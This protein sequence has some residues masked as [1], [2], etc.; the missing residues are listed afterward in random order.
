M[1]AGSFLTLFDVNGQSYERSSPCFGRVKTVGTLCPTQCRAQDK[2]VPPEGS[3]EPCD[4]FGGPVNRPS[5]T[6]LPFSQE[7]AGPLYLRHLGIRFF[8]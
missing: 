7:N 1:T 4:G 8:V 2:A 3:G 5:A 6:V